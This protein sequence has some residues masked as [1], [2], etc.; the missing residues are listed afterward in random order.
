MKLKRIICGVDFSDHSVKAFQATVELARAMRAEV[1]LVHVIESVPIVEKDVMALEEKARLALEILVRQ[2]GNTLDDGQL[3]TTVTTG[4]AFDELVHMARKLEADLAVLGPRGI[5]LL[6][7]PFIGTT[8]EHVL[9][10][11][12]CSVLVVKN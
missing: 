12:P 10:K 4:R 11:A 5:K 8:T 1:H 6:E 9:K 2:W 3:I 7:E